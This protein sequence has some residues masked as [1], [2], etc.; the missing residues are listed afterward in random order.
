[1]NS[2]A[3][4]QRS[5]A[6]QSERATWKASI[7]ALNYHEGL[8]AVAAELRDPRSAVA[9]FMVVAC[10]RA[11]RRVSEHVAWEIIADA[12]LAR[13]MNRRVRELTEGE[14]ERIAL[15]LERRAG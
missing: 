4:A 7:A 10:L 6:I 8:R 12:D 3:L 1:M 13:S 9:S 15:A 5:A 2:V 14:R 11:I